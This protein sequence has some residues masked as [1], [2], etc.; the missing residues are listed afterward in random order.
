M[1]KR[2]GN[3]LRPQVLTLLIF[4][5][6]LLLMPVLYITSE[7]ARTNYLPGERQ[8]WLLKTRIYESPL[9]EYL[10]HTEGKADIFLGILQRDF[11]D[12]YIGIPTLI[13]FYLLAAALNLLFKKVIALP[14]LNRSK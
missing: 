1:I 7:P 2:M 6:L 11:I 14:V 12:N 8:S 5:A 4:L 9:E 3:F 10:F 13:L